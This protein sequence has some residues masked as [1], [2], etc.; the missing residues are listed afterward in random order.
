M[1]DA[2]LS[3]SQYY[4]MVVLRCT[5]V[6]TLVLPGEMN[7]SAYPD[8]PEIHTGKVII[9]INLINLYDVVSIIVLQHSE[10]STLKRVEYILDVPGCRSR[11]LC[12][13]F[14]AVLD[15][16]QSVHTPFYGKV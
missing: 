12:T 11:R 13:R 3:H 2:Y 14:F 10:E 7:I 5:L 16:R 15:L 4:E 8:I 1:R 9:H 6:P